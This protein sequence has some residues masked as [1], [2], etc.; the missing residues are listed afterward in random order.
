MNLNLAI[1]DDE[2]K[3]IELLK[4]HILQ[5]TIE[6]DNNITVSSY[7]SAQKLISEYNNHSYNVVLLDIEMP[8]LSGM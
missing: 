1:C 2:I 8:D 3:D 4:K 7:T 5:Y 6:T